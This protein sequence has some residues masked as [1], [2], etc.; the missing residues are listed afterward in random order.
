MFDMKK[1]VLLFIIFSLTTMCSQQKETHV[2]I[3]TNLGDIKV[4]L[5][6]ETPLHRDNFIKLVKEGFYEGL[7]FHRVINEFMVQGGDPTLRVS[8]QGEVADTTDLTYTIPAEFRTPAIYHKRGSLAAARYGDNVNPEKESSGSQFYIVTGKRF[9]EEELDYLE[10]ER[11][12]ALRGSILTEIQQANVEKI[13]ELYA[14]E[15][16]EALADFRQSMIAEADS[17]IKVRKSEVTYT[18]IQRESYL[19]E[20]GTPH[21]DGG[22]TVFGEVVEGMDVVSQIERVETNAKDKPLQPI[23][24]QMVLL[25]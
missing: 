5:Y 23:V 11:V 17:L 25:D 4:K 2:L 6:N 12:N 3:R 13:K 7:I 22:Y 9:T 19:K 18:P 14:A 8:L 21:L 15:D 16:K 10:E 24:F 20:G 1:Y